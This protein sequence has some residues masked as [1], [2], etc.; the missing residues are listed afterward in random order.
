MHWATS[1]AVHPLPHSACTLRPRRQL[2][3]PTPQFASYLEQAFP[4]AKVI[5]RNGAIPASSAAY[6]YM[7]FEMA[8][9]EDIDLLFIEFTMNDGFE[10]AMVDNSRVKVM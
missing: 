6:S 3:P 8:V 10:D 5:R 1:A 7:C 9:D 2:P 4:R